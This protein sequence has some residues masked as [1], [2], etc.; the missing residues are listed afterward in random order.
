MPANSAF[1]SIHV[2]RLNRSSQFGEQWLPPDY[3]KK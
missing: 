1:S 2:K 3:S